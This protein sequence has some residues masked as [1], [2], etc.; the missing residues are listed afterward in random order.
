MAEQAPDGRVP[1]MRVRRIWHGYTTPENADTY[2]EILLGKVIPDIEA[3]DIPGLEG[4]EVFRRPHDEDDEVEFITVMGFETIDAVRA[5]VGDDYEVA[6]VPPEARAV[7]KR[8]DE[9]VR[10]Y[11]LV[12]ERGRSWKR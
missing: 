6:H 2:Q 5:F 12:G 8:Y 3:M 1:Q 7:L 11:D 9:R 4:I 10:H